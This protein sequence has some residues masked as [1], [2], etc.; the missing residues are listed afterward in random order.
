MFP[1]S[2]PGEHIANHKLTS[3]TRLVR[4]RSITTN[5]IMQQRTIAFIESLS[6][7]RSMAVTRGK[8]LSVAMAPKA[9]KYCLPCWDHSSTGLPHPLRS[10]PKFA[11]AFDA[12]Y[13]RSGLPGVV[14]DSC[15][16]GIPPTYC[17]FSKPIYSCTSGLRD[18]VS[19]T[20][21]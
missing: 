8:P 6:I 17:I 2:Y 18:L 4:G 12:R 10:Q 16:Q 1:H 7:E 19:L 21:P 14:Q 9:R 11:A 15:M 13:V 20:N 5:M 3:D